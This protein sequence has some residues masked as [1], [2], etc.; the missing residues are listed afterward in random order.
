LISF[1]GAAAKALQQASNRM[2]GFMAPGPEQHK[3][4]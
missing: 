3:D 1:A 4:T 2:I